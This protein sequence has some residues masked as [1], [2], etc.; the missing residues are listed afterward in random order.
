MGQ[1]IYNKSDWV[2]GSAHL[3]RIWQNFPDLIFCQF[4]FFYIV[5]MHN[6]VFEQVF[7]HV[8]G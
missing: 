2:D 3:Y 4:Y 5:W 8:L 1:I 6:F 7:I